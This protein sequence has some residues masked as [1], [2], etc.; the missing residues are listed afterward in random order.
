V[1][2]QQAE[3]SANRVSATATAEAPA[4]I[5]I[6]Q[7]QYPAWKAFV[8]GHS[9]PL[10]RAN[11]AFQAVEMPPGKH[12]LRLEY[13]DTMFHLG[14]AITALSVLICAT[15]FLRSGRNLARIQPSAF[16]KASSSC[17]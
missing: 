12:D 17:A 14:A 6:S 15:L 2:I 5:V 7:N 9:T 13:R 1:Q 16:S 4:L 3:F 8:D 10:L 11:H